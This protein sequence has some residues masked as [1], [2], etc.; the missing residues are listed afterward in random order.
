MED[1]STIVEWTFAIDDDDRA[2]LSSIA[3]AGRWQVRVLEHKL[4][5][6]LTFSTARLKEEILKQTHSQ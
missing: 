2:A 3:P 5:N 1:D 4:Q 6:V